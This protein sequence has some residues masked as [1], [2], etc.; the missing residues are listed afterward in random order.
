MYAR[1]EEASGGD[2]VYFGR[3][4][5]PHLVHYY[6]LHLSTY[7]NQPLVRLAFVNAK[8]EVEESNQ[9]T[10]KEANEVI[11][12]WKRGELLGSFAIGTI[13]AKDADYQI[14]TGKL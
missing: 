5:M 4:V 3:V 1:C 2:E 14:G 6:E 8:G 12:N 9:L 11:M 10:A 7:H 13:L